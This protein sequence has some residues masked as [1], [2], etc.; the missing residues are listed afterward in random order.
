VQTLV[1]AGAL[2][3]LQT[4]SGQTP[5]ELAQAGLKPKKGEKREQRNEELG[6]GPE[7]DVPDCF[8]KVI[9]VLTK[10]ESGR[11]AQEKHE[12]PMGL[13]HTLPKFKDSFFFWEVTAV[14]GARKHKEKIKAP[15]QKRGGLKAG[16]K[17][18]MEY[19]VQWKGY[20]E[21][22][23]SWVQEKEL[24]NCKGLLQEYRREVEVKTRQKAY[25]PTILTD[26]LAPE[27]IT[28]AQKLS[29]FASYIQEY[30]LKLKA[31]SQTDPKLSCRDREITPELKEQLVKIMNG[32]HVND[33][34]ELGA[35]RDEN[36]PAV[37]Y[38]GTQVHEKENFGLYA[39]RTIPADT[40]LGEYVG[41]V[42]RYE[43]CQRNADLE[44]ELNQT[45]YFDL[46]E[47]QKWGDGGKHK[48]PLGDTLVI[49]PSLICNELV[50]MND[51]RSEK[52]DGSRRQNV[53]F[54][55]ILVNGW[56]HIYAITKAKT[57]VAP[58]AEL[59]T[60][61]GQAWWENFRIVMR[62]QA[63]LRTIKEKWTA[64]VAATIEEN[65]RLTKELAAMRGGKEA[66]EAEVA[67]LKKQLKK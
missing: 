66:L 4:G 44:T 2:L 14:L 24:A 21:A 1:D 30:K 22:E 25:V 12:D 36:N 8:S 53:A 48:C 16:G 55:E 45:C 31:G 19:Q 23:A 65:E 39:L 59:L 5:R 9:E 49:D 10:A 46:I 37:R 42:Q 63:N 52:M 15:K 18:T 43:D 38:E 58:G 35:I 3:T 29:K 67:R 13:L 60:N 32:S 34:F 56:P 62:R 64:G 61:Y 28:K 27:R 6:V 26:V 33:F 54:H 17:Q 20:T 51:Y 7:T 50:Y 47:S 41:T 11:G 40:I 57:E